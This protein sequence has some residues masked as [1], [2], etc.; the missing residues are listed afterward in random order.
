MSLSFHSFQPADFEGA[1]DIFMSNTPKFLDISERE[2]LQ[3][4]LKNRA[5]DSYWVLK[6]D[7]GIAL[8]SGGIRLI[9][10]HEGGL[11]WG[12]VRAD[13]HGKNLGSL[14][15]THRL[16]KL[17]EMPA[18][19]EIRLDTSQHTSGFFAKYGFRAWDKITESEYKESTAG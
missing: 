13:H 18:I 6:N 3:E 19:K 7:A 9:S 14:L 15:L 2:E 10:P 17:M 1:I 8:A 16:L 12:M 4:Y 11:A 5:A